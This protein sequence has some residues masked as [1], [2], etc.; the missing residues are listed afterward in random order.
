MRASSA[1]DLCSALVAA[2]AQ[3][4]NAGS[5]RSAISSLIRLSSHGAASTRLKKDVPRAR[6]RP[7][8]SFLGGACPDFTQPP[9]SEVRARR[10]RE[11]VHLLPTRTRVRLVVVVIE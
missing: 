8:A 2:A 1:S 3:D 9:L 11:T 10:G 6:L 5:N 7:P 4:A